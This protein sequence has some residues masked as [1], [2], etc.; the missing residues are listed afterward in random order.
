MA[1]M[2]RR[3]G[4]C[5]GPNPAGCSLGPRRWPWG[6][7]QVGRA[8]LWEQM[9]VLNGTVEGEGFWKRGRTDIREIMRK[10]RGPPSSRIVSRKPVGAGTDGA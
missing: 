2:S 1:P 7:R 8:V 4:Y 9:E 10:E 5:H 3:G 6:R